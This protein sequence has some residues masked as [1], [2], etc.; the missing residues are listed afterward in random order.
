MFHFNFFSGYRCSKLRCPDAKGCVL[1][2]CSE[3]A[4]CSE[5]GDPHE[6][7]CNPGFSG[8]GLVCDNIND[9]PGATFE[10]NDLQYPESGQFE[11]REITTFATSVTFRDYELNTLSGDG[12]VSDNVNECDD[13]SHNCSTHATCIDN[14]GSYSCKCQPGHTGD[15]MDC[16]LSECPAGSFTPDGNTCTECPLN[17]YNSFQDALLQEC[18]PCPNHETT[19]NNGSTS[20]TQCKCKYFVLN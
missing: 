3:Q 19:E 15:G 17:T 11:T 9:V 5:D 4:T 8:D 18:L 1:Q 13:G 16:K 2:E 20:I 12:L 10:D 6:C 7:Y 14:E